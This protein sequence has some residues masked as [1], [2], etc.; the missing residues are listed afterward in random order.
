ME[1]V[2][3]PQLRTFSKVIELETFSAAAEY[4]GVTQPAITIQISEL[5]KAL[6]VRVV[7]RSSRRTKPTEAGKELLKHVVKIDAAISKM[8]AGMEKHR[9]DVGK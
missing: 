2:K 5:E 8:L 7:E 1:R 9:G 4:F 3:L 6:G